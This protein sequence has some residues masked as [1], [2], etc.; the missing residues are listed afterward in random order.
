[1]D[2]NGKSLLITGGTGSLGKKLVE[3]ILKNSPDIKRLVIFS[4]DEQ[5]QFQMAKIFSEEKY[6]ALR[7]FIGDVR[8]FQISDSN[9]QR[10]C[11]A[12]SALVMQTA[13]MRD[14]KKGH[15]WR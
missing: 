3:T 10:Q 11:H 15:G 4:R 5:K 9:V 14:G 13:K 12:P 7:Y 2:L 8:D 1:M 6:P